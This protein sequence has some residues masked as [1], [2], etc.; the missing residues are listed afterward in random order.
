MNAT[1][2]ELEQ[3]ATQLSAEDRAQFALYLLQSLEPADEGD[4]GE[5]W[6]IESERRLAQI[7]SGEV[8]SVPGDD[9]FARVRR[10]L[11]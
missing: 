8:Q 2:A 9:V 10:R 1:L 4:I 3:K 7:E 11:G 5:A 6:R